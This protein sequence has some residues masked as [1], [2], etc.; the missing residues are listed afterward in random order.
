MVEGNDHGICIHMYVHCISRQVI[1]LIFYSLKREFS[2]R[3]ASGSN[4]KCRPCCDYH[5]RC[6]EVKLLLDSKNA[7][8][9]I[10]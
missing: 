5:H 9:G 6:I 2:F 3:V 7:V 8:P 10:R 1:P 4:E